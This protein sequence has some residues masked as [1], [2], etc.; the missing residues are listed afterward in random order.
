[1]PELPAGLTQ[2][3]MRDAIHLERRVEFACEGFY[4]N[5]I[6]RWK[7]AEQV[8][9]ATIYNSQ[10]QAIVQRSFDASRDYWWPV[11]QPQRDL[12]PNLSQNINY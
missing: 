8:M 4:Y 6:R 2:A 5:D 11:P 7:T 9:N 10:G 1:M 12:D 3:Q